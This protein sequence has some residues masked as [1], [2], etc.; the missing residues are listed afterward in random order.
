MTIESFQETFH[1][2]KD[3]NIPLYE[4]LISYFRL[5]IRTGKLKSGDQI[6]AETDICHALNISRSTVRRAMDQLVAEGLVVRY[7]RKGSFI[8]DGKMKRPIN[9]LYNFTENMRE[10]GANPSSRV[11]LCAVENAEPLVRECLRLP[12]GSAKVFHLLR[13]RCTGDTPIL[14]EDTFVPYYLCPGIE[15]IDFSTA[16]LY[17][18]LTGQYGLN[19]YH[20]TETIEAICVKGKTADLLSCGPGDPGYRITRISHLSSGT[21]FEYTSSITNA[22][23]CMFQLELY[24]SSKASKNEVNFERR[25]NLS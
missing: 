8:S 9:H 7:R 18:T 2:E 14:L 1:I 3:R 6:I 13:L 19:L 12:A 4:Q 17:Q 10:L 22:S 20:A 25:V 11:L 21:P 16:S 5:M 23:R 15:A 24:Q